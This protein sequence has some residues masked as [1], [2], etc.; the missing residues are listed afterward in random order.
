MNP[1]I[2]SIL[3]K[4]YN[5]KEEIELK[6]QNILAHLQGQYIAEAIASTIGNAFRKKGSKPYQYPKK[7]Y[8]FNKKEELTEG[9]LQKQR[10][11]F[12]A[13]LEVMKTNY[14]LSHKNKDSTGS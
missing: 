2:I 9:E 1:H 4:G 8:E 7:P 6:K 10:E 3:I 11:L 12:V 13:K 14:E 5:E